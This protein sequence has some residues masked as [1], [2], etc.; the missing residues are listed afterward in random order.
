MIMKLYRKINKNIPGLKYELIQKDNENCHLGQRKLLFA[1]IE[2]LN[3][4]SKF[5]ELKDCLIV[6][7]GSASGVH[8]N[9]LKKLYP[10]THYLLYDPRDFEIYFTEDVKICKQFYER[11]TYKDVIKYKEE[12]GKKYIIYIT[13]IR[14]QELAKDEPTIWEDMNLQQL[15]GIQMNADFMS[16]KFRL[17]W[18]SNEYPNHLFNIDT[19]GIEDRVNIINDELKETEVR[20]LK[21]KIY[22]QIYAFKRSTESRLFVK[23]NRDNKYDIIN[24]DCEKYE[25][26]FFYFNTKE[27]DNEFEFKESYILED[28]LVGYNKSY[29]SVS[30]Y[31]I[32]YKYLKNYKKDLSDYNNKIVKLLFNISFKW[33]HYVN[34]KYI[35]FCPVYA[36]IDFIREFKYANQ[37]KKIEKL[38]D[39]TTKKLFEFE[40][41]INNKITI[42]EKNLD[43]ESFKL[44]MKCLTKKIY[45]TY[46][47]IPYILLD[48]KNNQ[49]SINRELIDKVQI[50]LQ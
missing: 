40:K 19:D 3:Y 20:Y 23:K 49:F 27:K 5:V 38:K 22:I 15:W 6:Y 16:I 10:E 48:Y 17:P 21:G 28:K 35:I 41:Y 9:T 14:T 50:E 24:Y 1:E 4:V 37:E 13:D 32:M 36:Y 43:D 2:F 18:L 7:V 33:A 47:K 39:Y 8:I 25:H 34:D 42:V 29:D 31:F 44:M 12:I 45:M 30:E 46:K 26:R 11:D